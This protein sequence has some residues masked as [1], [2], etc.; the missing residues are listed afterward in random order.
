MLLHANAIA[1]LVELRKQST[2]IE[3][4]AFV[5]YCIYTAGTVHVHGAHY[6]GGREGEV[7]SASADFSSREMQQ[8]SE[9]QYV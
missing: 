6:K 2:S 3:W 1:E 9:L 8:L 4:P 5:G 7:F